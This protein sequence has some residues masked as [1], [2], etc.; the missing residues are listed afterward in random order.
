MEKDVNNKNTKENIK[1]QRLKEAKFVNTT[2]VT[3]DMINKFYKF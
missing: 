1:K 2:K 3:E